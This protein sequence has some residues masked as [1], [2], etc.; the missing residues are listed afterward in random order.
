MRTWN[1]TALLSA[2]LAV[3]LTGCAKQESGFEKAGRE[4][5]SAINQVSK[6]MDK[7]FNK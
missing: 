6:D 2:C 7:T 1:V 3:A 4:M 5:D